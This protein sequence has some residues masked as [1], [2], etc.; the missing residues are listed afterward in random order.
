VQFPL[1]KAFL[2]LLITKLVK[3][4]VTAKAQNAEIK[5]AL[6]KNKIKSA[7]KITNTSRKFEAQ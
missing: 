2:V 3:F 6:K 4:K 5:K 1:E 7:K